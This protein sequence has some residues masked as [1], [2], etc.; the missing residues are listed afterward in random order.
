MRRASGRPVPGDAPQHA[1]LQEHVLGIGSRFQGAFGDAGGQQDGDGAEDGLVVLVVEAAVG[2][3][4]DHFGHTV[5][6][7]PVAGDFVEPATR[8]VR[9]GKFGRKG[10][11]Q[12]D[13]LLDLLVVQPG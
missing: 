13:D 6:E 12:V 8:G 4:V 5:F 2:R 11:R 10:V 7:L 9:R 1:E 3:G